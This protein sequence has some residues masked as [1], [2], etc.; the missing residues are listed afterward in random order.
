[1]QTVSPDRRDKRQT[2]GGTNDAGQ[3]PCSA[4]SSPFETYVSSLEAK[5]G[6]I[7]KLLYWVIVRQVTARVFGNCHL[8]AT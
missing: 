1:M 4:H 6:E 8:D 2:K 5:L 3:N 7:V